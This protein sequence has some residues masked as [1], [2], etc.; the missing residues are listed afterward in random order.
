PLLSCDENAIPWDPQVGHAPLVVCAKKQ[1]NIALLRL[2]RLGTDRSPLRTH[3]RE[4]HCQSSPRASEKCIALKLL[5]HLGHRWLLV[6]AAA[7][8]SAAHLATAEAGQ[9]ELCD[10][11]KAGQ[12]GYPAYRIPALLTTRSGALLAF[13]EA[14]AHLRDHAENDLVLKRSSD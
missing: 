7:H 12:D 3:L 6:F 2:I 10:V 5:F 13:T 11:F 4:K 1:I 9:P 14:R 8:L